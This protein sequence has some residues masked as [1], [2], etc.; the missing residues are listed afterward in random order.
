MLLEAI[1]QV[2]ALAHPSYD[3]LF[4]QPDAAVGWRQ[5]PNMAWTWA[6]HDWYA[7][8]F[9][10]HV[11]T[12]SSGYRDM[13]RDRA[14]PSE[15]ARVALLGDSFIEAV[16]VPFEKTSGHLLEQRLNA[17]AVVDHQGPRSWEVL[18][19]G[20]SNYGVGQYL[21]TWE[22]TARQYEPDYVAI[23]VAKFIMARTL[24]RYESGAFPGSE[25]KR[26]WVRPT[27][28]LQGDGT[29]LKEPARDYDEFVK[30]QQRL[31]TTQFHGQ[32]SK[33][34]I[35]LVTL[36]YASLLYERLRQALRHARGRTVP[37]DSPTNTKNDGQLYAVNARLLQ[38]LQRDVARSGA[39][40]VVVDASK[41]FGDEPD[42]TT[43]LKDFCS[44]S[45]SVYLPFYS[46]LLAAND[47]GVATHWLHDAHF[48]DAGNVILADA[49]FRSISTHAPQWVAHAAPGEPPFRTMTGR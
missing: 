41:Y 21:L 38:D 47:K 6:G 16:Q 8:D 49:L 17:S 19:F 27:F 23:F 45:D 44:R 42:V 1:G 18:N 3:V 34:R 40:L 31:I 36:H 22:Q 35:S 14:K 46:D 30:M 4:L 39:V 25:Q 43:F 20:I 32:H 33:R 5:V 12:N 28:D 24:Q 26:L 7:S 2:V 48:N 9:S 15:V 11:Q 37:N 29:L 10:V 13:T